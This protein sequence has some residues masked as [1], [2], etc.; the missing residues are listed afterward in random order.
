MTR[1]EHLT[2]RAHLEHAADGSEGGDAQRG[3]IAEQQ[4]D[5]HGGAARRGEM[6]LVRVRVWA[7]VR[8]WVRVRANGLGL[9]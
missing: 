9:G 5:Q 8:V 2:K 3:V 7:R 6:H 4:V 1:V